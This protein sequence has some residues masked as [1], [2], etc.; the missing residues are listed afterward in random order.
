M[1]E[2]MNRIRRPRRWWLPVVG[3][4]LSALGLGL[5][6]GLGVAHRALADEV[7]GLFHL[8]SPQVLTT[9][10]DPVAFMN[11]L[12][13]V[14]P[15]PMVVMNRQ[16]AIASELLHFTRTMSEQDVLRVAKALCEEGD[17][18]GWDPLMYLAVIHV[19][20]NYDHLAV[21]PVG[22]EGLMQLMPATAEWMA[23]QLDDVDW[24]ENHSFDPVLN[25]RLGARYLAHLQDSLKRMDLVLTAYNRGPR[26]TR[27]LVARYGELPQDIRDFYATKVIERYRFLRN[28]YGNLP[29]G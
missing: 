28:K 14:L 23:E 26:A 19:E 11:E 16:D 15:R 2:Y 24:P 9:P 21:S 5:G 20:S 8:N 10:R 1:M 17:E 6:L 27:Y 4:L 29:L 13:P 18:L 22:A 3:V 25:V 7:A 12:E